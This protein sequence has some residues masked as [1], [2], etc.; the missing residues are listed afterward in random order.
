MAMKQTQTKF[1]AFSDVG[2]DLASIS[3]ARIP[4]AFKKVLNTGYNEQTVLSVSVTGNQVVFTYGGVHGYTESRVLKVN[5]GPLSEINAGE[6]HIDSVTVNTVTL[7]IDDAPAS[8]SGGFKTVVAP[9][10]WDLVYELDLVQLYKMRYLDE[11]EL[12]VRFVFSPATGQHKSTSNVCV[13]KTANEATGEITDPDTLD[14]GKTNI[15]PMIGLQW[16]FSQQV[17]ASDAN[18]TAA[19]GLANYGNFFIVGSKYH[20]TCMSNGYSSNYPGRFFAIL[21][22]HVYDF[23]ALDYPLIIGMRSIT[24]MNTA[25]GSDYYQFNGQSTPPTSHCY[26]G[27]IPVALDSNSNANAGDVINGQTLAAASFFPESLDTFNTFAA[28]PITLYERTTRQF[29]GYVSGGAYRSEVLYGQL[30]NIAAVSL[31]KITSDD[32]GVTLPYQVVWSNQGS[33]YIHVFTAPVEEIKI[34]S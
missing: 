28:A 12:Y 6:F 1:F 27:K 11:R 31:P 8:I 34:E 16:M 21:P 22:A 3:R 2:L 15:I 10:G 7:T 4:A 32:Y 5:S 29:L 19:Q 13:G 9:L 33:G 23:D 30:G 18:F 14:D 24:V 26:I 20:L 17:N 25:S